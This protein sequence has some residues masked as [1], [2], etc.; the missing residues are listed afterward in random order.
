MKT[1]LHDRL[2]HPNDMEDGEKVYNTNLTAFRDH[3][4]HGP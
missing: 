1:F 4:F 3:F 2:T